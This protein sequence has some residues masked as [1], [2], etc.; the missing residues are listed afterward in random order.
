M[1]RAAPRKD[2]QVQMEEKKRQSE[3]RWSSSKMSGVLPGVCSAPDEMHVIHGNRTLQ[4]GERD[5]QTDKETCTQRQGNRETGESTEILLSKCM[6][7]G[8]V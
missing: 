5:R 1:W 8:W 6:Y 4:F 3:S 7:E 2:P